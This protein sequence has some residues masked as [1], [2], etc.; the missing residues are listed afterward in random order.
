MKNLLLV[1]HA[2]AEP[3][4][5]FDYDFTRHLVKKGL[6]DAKKMADKIKNRVSGKVLFI[7]SNSDRA[8]ETAHIFAGRLDYPTTKIFLKDFIYHD[9]KPEQLSE[10]IKATDD[11][12]DTVILFG[13][14]P[15]LSLF[16]S[17]LI[18]DF[19]FDI[20]KCGVAAFEF[21]KNS[22]KE[23]EKQG[24][25]LK[26]AEYPVKKSEEFSLFEKTL[27][28]KLSE[29][30]SESLKSINPDAATNL[31]K[32]IAKHSSKLAKNFTG[33]LKQSRVNQK[34]KNRV[35]K[36]VE[37]NVNKTIENKTDDKAKDKT[38]DKKNSEADEPSTNQ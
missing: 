24:G 15:S 33:N 31:I 7:S 30:I 34:F 10:L 2:K 32:S 20:P 25:V 12:Y 3:M 27:V 19:E 37:E 4:R 18:K 13:H 35:S 1:R 6:K 14:N 38:E 11:S 23:I 26:Y 22:W 36:Q 17:S 29:A 8:F 28:M 16:A 21:D 5:E 9:P